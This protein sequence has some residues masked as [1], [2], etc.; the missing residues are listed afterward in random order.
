MAVAAGITAAAVLGLA[1]EDGRDTRTGQGELEAVVERLNAMDQWLAQADEHLASQQR[2]L[3]ATDLRI[4]DHARRVRTLRSEVADL[5]A[6]QQRN[7]AERDRLAAE[8]VRL[9]TRL[10]GH[11]R[12]AWRLS[13]RDVVKQVL[14][15]ERPA[16][17]ERLMRYHGL[18]AEARSTDL[19][20][21]KDSQVAL[22]DSDARLADEREALT[23]AQAA[24]DEGRGTLLDERREQRRLLAGFKSEVLVKRRERDTLAADRKR[25]EALLREV[26][27]QTALPAG[28][29]HDQGILL[30]PVPGRLVHRFDD[31]RAGGR[32]RWQ[33]VYL[34]AP[35]GTN[36]VAVASGTVAFADWLRGFGMLAIID[37]GNATMSLYGHADTLY[38]KAGDRVEGGEPI[39]SV[40]QS[41]SVN[42]VGVYFEIRRDGVPVDPQAWLQTRPGEATP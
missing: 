26:A 2:A 38:K 17:A 25:L 30:W 18:L 16:D 35:L 22:T 9:A 39:A 20:A 6:V 13:G 37:H 41:G 27:R 40:G 23:V 33:G 19:A 12:M 21:L 32:M 15:Q 42:E 28:A 24:L 7:V 10:A 11:L 31:S 36:V 29:R 1:A 5:E 34:S 8:S 14:N 3:D 4:A